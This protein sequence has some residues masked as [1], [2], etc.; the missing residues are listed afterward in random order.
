MWGVGSQFVGGVVPG[1]VFSVQLVRYPM[2]SVG[3]SN[4][5]ACV[6]GAAWASRACSWC[7]VTLV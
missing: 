6:Q 3:V 5:V 7:G 1:G 2:V 4:G